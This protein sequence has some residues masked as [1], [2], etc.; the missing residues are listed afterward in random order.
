ME[1]S[2][3][4]YMSFYYKI[5]KSDWWLYTSEMKHLKRDLFILVSALHL[6]DFKSR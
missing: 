3:F 4:F 5:S 1:A 2:V 6:L